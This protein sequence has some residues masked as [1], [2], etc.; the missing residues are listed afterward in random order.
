GW[1]ADSSGKREIAQPAGR[2]LRGCGL[3][4]A[5]INGLNSKH[6]LADLE[7]GEGGQRF[8][9]ERSNRIVVLR[10]IERSEG[11]HVEGLPLLRFQSPTH[12]RP[13][14]FGASSVKICSQRRVMISQSNCSM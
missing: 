3:V 1:Q 10:R 11:Q 7:L 5:P 13:V 6:C 14:N 4:S 2:N 12:P 9:D 8:V